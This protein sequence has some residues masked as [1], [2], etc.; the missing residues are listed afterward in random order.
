MKKIG[1]VL[2]TI[3]FCLNGM[4][5]KK[6]EKDGKWGLSK[7]GGQDS[8]IF[9]ADYEEINELE[10]KDGTFFTGFRNDEWYPLTTNKIVNQQRYES[11]EVYPFANQFAVCLRDG[12]ID[13]IDVANNDFLIRGVQATM[14]QESES[15]LNGDENLLLTENNKA[16]GVID[17]AQKKEVL[18]AKYGV[19]RIPDLEKSH[20]S[21]FTFQDE[22]NT[23]FDAMGK[24]LFQIPS[25]T[26][27]F[28]ITQFTSNSKCYKLETEKGSFGMYD[29]TN[30]WFV[31][32]IFT[33]LK[34]MEK[35]NAEIVITYSKKGEGV[36]F[37]GKVLAEAIYEHVEKSD[38]RGY[39]AILTKKGKQY[40][41][42]PEGKISLKPTE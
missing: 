14:L 10:T 30:K 24:A 38:T 4:S 6:F 2:L 1:L 19:I 8:V 23:C 33:D 28:K 35:D 41:L 42:S 15:V 20:F 36:Y 32:M 12:Y 3:A 27:V 22:K 25:T 40:F 16:F 18:K 29:A 13:L 26:E 34:M 17:I 37:Q 31:P 7:N 21:F 5:Q 11:I 9:R 39:V